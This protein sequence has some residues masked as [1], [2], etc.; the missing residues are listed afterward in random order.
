MLSLVATL[1][2]AA[3][4]PLHGPAM[5]HTMHALAESQARTA[6]T[7]AV[8]EIM[9]DENELLRLCA[10]TDRGQRCSDAQMAQLRSLITRIESDAPDCDATDLNGEWLLL[11]AL[12]ESPYRSSPFF[13]A[14]RQA[15]GSMTTPIAIPNPSV[16]AGGPL[17]SAIYAITD[18]IPLYDIGSV[19]QKISGVCSENAGCVLAELDDPSQGPTDGT[20]GDEPSEGSYAGIPSSD[21]G[22]LTSEV[23]LVIGRNF[24]LPAAQSLMTTTCTM[25]ELPDMRPSPSIV[26]CEVRVETTAAKQS[27]IAALF[28][29]ADELLSFPTGE[30]LDAM[31][32]K[33]STVRLM[34]TYLS[35]S[36]AGLRI[37]RP[38]IEAGDMSAGEPPVFVYVRA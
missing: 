33:S 24:G 38:L 25:R 19:V 34:T 32:A 7:A 29:S 23:E 18:A 30:A 3:Y 16:P 28:P 13:W 4:T 10:L 26:N 14:F 27:T 6:R 20:S 8:M 17:A 31:S 1:A 22:T 21:A 9:D 5:R 2:A 35:S 36:A 15:A 37:S 11:A 12:G